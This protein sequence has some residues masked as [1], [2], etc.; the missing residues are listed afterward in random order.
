[1]FGIIYLITNKITGEMYVGQTINKLKERWWGHCAKTI[2][3]PR[4]YYAIKKYGKDQFYIDQIDSGSSYVELGIKEVYWIAKLNTLSPNG[5]NLT[6]GSKLCKI[7]EETK[8]KIGLASKGNKHNLGRKATQ[9]AKL[10]MS[11]ARIGNKYASG[12]KI[13]DDEKRRRSNSVKGRCLHAPMTAAG[14]LKLSIARKNISIETR[15]KLSQAA[16]GQY[17]KKLPQVKY[18]GVYLC[19]KTGKYLVNITSN[20]N[21]KKYL[22]SFNTDI[23]AALAYDKAALL[24]HGKEGYLNFPN[25]VDIGKRYLQLSFNF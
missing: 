12:R 17:K 6:T 15:A 20:V 16:A 19:K 7:S 23:E 10:K 8:K 4:L 11:A 14:K 25:N 2:A 1:M 13:P 22:G 5:Y 18:K 9:E 21:T 24:Y 3:C